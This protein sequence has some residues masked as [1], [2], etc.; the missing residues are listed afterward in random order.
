[1]HGALIIRPSVAGQA[2][3]SPTTAYDDE[4]VLVLSEIDPAL[5]PAKRPPS[6]CESSSRGTS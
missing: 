1:M 2:Y 5:T 4:A 3:D 6:T